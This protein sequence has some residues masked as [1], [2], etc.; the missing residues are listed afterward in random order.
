MPILLRHGWSE[1]NA[2]K[3]FTSWVNVPLTE[4]GRGETK[5]GGELLKSAGLL[6]ENLYT[7]LLRRPTATVDFRFAFLLFCCISE[8]HLAFLLRRSAMDFDTWSP[9]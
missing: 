3:R 9:L 8:C 4:K 5:H 6:S 2:S 7:S 1:W